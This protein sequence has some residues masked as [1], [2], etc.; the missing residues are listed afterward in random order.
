MK[1]KKRGIGQVTLIIIILCLVVAL[2]LLPSVANW[3]EFFSKEISIEAC[4]LSALGQSTAKGFGK[5]P[6]KLNCPRKHIAFY[7]DHV[8]SRIKNKG[9]KEKV[10]IN[11]KLTD[12]FNKLNDDIVNKVVVNEM[13]DCWYKFGKGEWN[14]FESKWVSKYVIGT[15]D[16]VCAVCASFDFNEETWE[17]N[18]GKNSTEYSGYGAIYNYIQNEIPGQDITY[19]KYFAG[20]VKVGKMLYLSEE[21]DRLQ[22]NSPNFFPNKQYSV[23]FVGLKP[24]TINKGVS[25]SL[26]LLS[27]LVESLDLVDDD[28]FFLLVSPTEDLPEM[29]S[30]LIN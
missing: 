19:A 4:K 24:Q 29:C 6:V 14:I 25:K 7:N 28:Q 10:M 22:I 17:Q 27:Y 2:I 23:F 26:S 9:D 16:S 5:T 30:I 15:Y 12:K 18:K 20:K 21:K 8:E 13:K 11:G 3:G 1:L